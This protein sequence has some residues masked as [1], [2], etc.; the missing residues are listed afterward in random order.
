ELASCEFVVLRLNGLWQEP[1]RTGRYA[2]GYLALV[3]APL[4]FA[5]AQAREALGE[6]DRQ[7]ANEVRRLVQR[8][9]DSSRARLQTLLQR[10]PT[11]EP[12]H[13]ASW[14]ERE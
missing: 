2:L 7:K 3:L 11:Y 8:D 9:A 14:R 4:L 10:Y 5:R 13:D 12:G 1:T 6:Y